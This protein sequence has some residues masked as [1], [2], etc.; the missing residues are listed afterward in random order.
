[1]ARK[2]VTRLQLNKYKKTYFMINEI[3]IKLAALNYQLQAE[4]VHTWKSLL[5]P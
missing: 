2:V 3:G 1:M 5:V 4:K